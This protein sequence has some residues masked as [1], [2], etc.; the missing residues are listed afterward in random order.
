MTQVAAGL[1]EMTRQLNSF[2]PASADV[3]GDLKE[4]LS[5][6]VTQKRSVW[7]QKVNQL[8]ESLKEQKKSVVDSAELLRDLMIGFENLGENVKDTQEEMDY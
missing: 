7:E 3:V 4:N 5:K 1:E 6:E 2:K 8:T